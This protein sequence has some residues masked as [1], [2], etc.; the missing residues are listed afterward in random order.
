MKF[1]LHLKP[2]KLRFSSMRRGR[3]HRVSMVL[4][5]ALLASCSSSDDAAKQTQAE[6]VEPSAEQTPEVITGTEEKPADNG[7]E[8][9]PT[10]TTTS[11]PTTTT[12]TTTTPTT[13]T[14]PTIV[15]TPVVTPTTPGEVFDAEIRTEAEIFA[16]RENSRYGDALKLCNATEPELSEEV[17]TLTKLPYIAMEDP[18]YTRET[19]MQ[20]VLVSHRWM[21][22][23]FEALLNDAPDTLLE[24]FGSTTGIIIS[25]DVRPS[26]YK[27]WTGGIRIDPRFLWMS[28]PEKRTILVQ[29]DFRADFDLEL[30]FQFI[31]DYIINNDWA[32]DY[33]S[34]ASD[35]TR[36]FEQLRFR[37]QRLMYHELGHAFD[38][39]PLDEIPN[40]DPNQSIFDAAVSMIERSGGSTL[41]TRDLP[42]N[43]AELFALGRVSFRGQEAT[44][45]Q[46]QVQPDYAGSL[47]ADDGASLYYNYST[48]R[49]DFSNILTLAMMAFHHQATLNIAYTNKPPEGATCNDYKIGWGVRDRLANEVV[50]AR[51]AYVV[52]RVYGESPQLDFIRNYTGQEELMEVGLGYCESQ[53]KPVIAQLRSGRV[54]ADIKLQERLA[55]ESWHWHGLMGNG[56]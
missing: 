56:H 7:E 18:Q 22:E 34:L 54:A 13:T 48:I 1:L 14:S 19:V 25:S 16:Y 31:S 42:L 23:R 26:N 12:P 2:A 32:S 4:V 17:C 27:S 53:F 15:T 52:E 38:F 41:L 46:K 37:F 40:L 33:V 36:T 11:T 6:P 29:D 30:Q 10:V 39:A 44:E 49:E 9:T 20:R 35:R 21:G 51:V 45:E 50:R 28:V 8:T 55:N 5:L 24:L 47:M 3:V 43:S